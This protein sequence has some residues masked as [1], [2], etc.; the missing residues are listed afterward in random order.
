MLFT[1]V[2]EFKAID[3]MKSEI[4]ARVSHELRTPVASVLMSADLLRE[5]VLGELSD[6][7]REMVTDMKT[8]LRRLSSMIDEILKA[9]RV[10]GISSLHDI[11][12]VPVED[13]L[14]ESIVR[15]RQIAVE[16]GVA[17]TVESSLPERFGLRILPEHLQLVF[18]NIVSNAIRFAGSG[19]SVR[20]SF[21][22]G[23]GGGLLMTV[24]DDGPGIPLSEQDRIFER[25]YQVD[26]GRANPP[27]SIGLGLSLVADV[28]RRYGGT[29][30][31]SSEEGEGALFTVEF[32]EEIVERE[33]HE[34]KT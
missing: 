4:L 5:G 19:G 3:A 30:S 20:I 18:D 28:V 2:T 33:D 7:Q 32:P 21:E 6:R 14:R 1:D 11:S 31:V 23:Q 26:R 24:A 9:A 17:L 34:G 25:F 29:V 16:S 22:G 8:D 10:E 15:H 27:G 12:P 13:S